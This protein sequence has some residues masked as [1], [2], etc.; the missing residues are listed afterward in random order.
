MS[1]DVIGSHDSD[2]DYHYDLTT[3]DD[4]TQ[5]NN[6]NDYNDEQ[7]DMTKTNVHEVAIS[8]TTNNNNNNHYNDNDKK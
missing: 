1:V 3:D 6:S 2:G 8:T 7:T 4:N 5:F